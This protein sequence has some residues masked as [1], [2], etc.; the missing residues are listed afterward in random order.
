[1]DSIDIKIKYKELPLESCFDSDT[2]NIKVFILGR[3]LV[4]KI[5]LQKEL[6]L[7]LK[8]KSKLSEYLYNVVRQ[9]FTDSLKFEIEEE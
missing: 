5:I 3:C 6:L 7:H 2:F 4:S 1:M 9:R 8:T